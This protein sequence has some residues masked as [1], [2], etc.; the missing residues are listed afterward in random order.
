[1]CA[2]AI[3]RH[4]KATQNKG[5]LRACMVLMGFRPFLLKSRSCWINFFVQPPCLISD[6]AQPMVKNTPPLFLETSVRPR[7]GSGTVNRYGVTAVARWWT[8][9]WSSTPRDAAPSDCTSCGTC[10]SASTS[11]IRS[12]L[13]IRCGCGYTMNGIYHEWNIPFIYRI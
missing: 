5:F 4:E 8:P 1:M 2:S 9:S 12:P 6:M 13:W 7:N 11:R 10:C 3:E